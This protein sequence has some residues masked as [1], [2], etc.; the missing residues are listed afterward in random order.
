MYGLAHWGLLPLP[1]R[2]LAGP[3][4]AV[5]A[6][7]PFRLIKQWFLGLW[8]AESRI[9]FSDGN[10]VDKAGENDWEFLNVLNIR[11]IV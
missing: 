8:S 7:S 10:N 2:S 9:F 1:H 3:G 4:P 11:T 6:I 5:G